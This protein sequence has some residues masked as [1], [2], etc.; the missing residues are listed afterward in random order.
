MAKREKLPIRYKADRE[1]LEP[2]REPY[3]DPLDP[4]TA[5]GFRCTGPDGRG[6]WIARLRTPNNPKH[7]HEYR[8]LKRDNAGN[9]IDDYPAAKKAAEAWFASMAAG[10]R[11]APVRGTVR[12]ALDAYVADLRKHGRESAA[13]DIEGR[14]KKGVHEARIASLRLDSVTR[15]DFEAWRDELRNGPRA[16]QPRSVN[17]QVRA[18]TAALNHAT[19]KLGHVGNKAAWTLTA[20][21]DD[22]EESGEAAVFLTGP[23]RERLI[24]KAPKELRAYLRGLEFSGARPSELAKATVADFDKAAGSLTLRHRKGRPA[25]LKARAVTLST[26]AVEFFT[27]Q[28]R[29]KAPDAPLIP[30]D[31]KHWR[32][33]EWSRGI[34]AAIEAANAKLKPTAP[35]RVPADASAYS[36]R[37]A[38]IS[39]LLQVYNVD[40]LTVA[41]QT[42]T[43]LA[44][45]E[46]YYFKFVPKALQDKLNAVVAA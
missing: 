29:G 14:F 35:A 46:K 13:T 18:L 5:V 36:F 32:T 10:A 26:A 8:A 39:E 28:V 23:Q 37:H 12:D 22:V 43:S 40:P 27:T 6:T 21:S 41:Q 17:R 24:G 45:M 4:G 15:D 31:G 34:R 11:R 44:M 2:R 19:A 9:P 7:Q 30:K 33:F 25:R 20:L 3:W 42:G 16:R 38:R 1:R